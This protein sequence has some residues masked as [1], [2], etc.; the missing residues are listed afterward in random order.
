MANHWCRKKK[1]VLFEYLNWWCVF[2][3]IKMMR[4]AWRNKNGVVKEGWEKCWLISQWNWANKFLEGVFSTIIVYITWQGIGL[5]EDNLWM[6]IELSMKLDSFV[7]WS[8]RGNSSLEIRIFGLGIFIEI[9]A[10]DV[11]YPSQL[12]LFNLEF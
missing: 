1:G 6:F 11:S 7:S 4:N 2:I 8:S 12:I 5:N 10:L 3:W 9:I